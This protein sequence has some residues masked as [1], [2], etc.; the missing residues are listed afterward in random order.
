MA[1]NFP[2]F[3]KF[4]KISDLKKTLYHALEGC[5]K[6]NDEDQIVF[7][8]SQSPY[9][10]SLH[11]IKN[12]RSNNEA[13]YQCE[14]CQSHWVSQEDYL[15]NV[16]DISLIEHWNQ[17]PQLCPE[18]F[19]EVLHQIGKTNFLSVP[20]AATLKTGQF[21]PACEVHFIDES[22]V[23]LDQERPI[24][25][26][27]EVAWLEPSEFALPQNIREKTAEAWEIRMGFAPTAVEAKNGKVYLLHGIKHFFKQ[28]ELTGKDINKLVNQFEP[29]KALAGKYQGPEPAII[30]ADLEPKLMHW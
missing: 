17:K 3:N 14:R 7:V 23:W 15:K 10:K 11:K 2:F 9:K 18:P 12:L 21:I 22:P 30:I 26:I 20:A 24:F 1:L 13:L 27:D 28:D 6:C 5:P 4:F 16:Q 25:L 29:K 8:L 19:L